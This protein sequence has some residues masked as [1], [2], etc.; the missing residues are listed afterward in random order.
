MGAVLARI[1]CG[2]MLLVLASAVPQSFSGPCSARLSTIFYCLK[3]DILP[4]CKA[5]FPYFLRRNRIAQLYSFE[6]EVT[7]RPNVSRVV[8]LS[9]G[10]SSGTHEQITVT[11]G[12]L[13]IS[14]R[15]APSLTT[16]SVCNL[17]VQLLLGLTNDFTLGSKSH[18][19]RDYILLY[20]LTFS[21]LESQ[22][23]VFIS[24]KNRGTVFP[25]RKHITYPLRAQQV[26]AT[27]GFVNI[28][29]KILDIIRRPVFYLKLNSTL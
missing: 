14:C 20:H 26:N 27:Y 21:K 29:I 4:I 6:V 3:F 11:A 23:P 16:R 22:I 19:T 17:L 24:P 1:A 9:A 15:G 18:R 2:V 8:F 28:T 25:Q 13:W 7:S 10:H 5:T 12:H